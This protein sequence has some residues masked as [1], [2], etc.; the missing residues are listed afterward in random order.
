LSGHL[1][2]KVRFWDGRKDQPHHEI[3]LEGKITSLDVSQSKNEN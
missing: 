1:D 3:V 2:K